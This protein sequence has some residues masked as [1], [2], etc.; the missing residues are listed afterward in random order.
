MKQ[1]HQIRSQ[2]SMHNGS[3]NSC[4]NKASR[5]TP[6]ISEGNSDVEEALVFKNDRL[7]VRKTLIES[8]QVGGEIT[9][10]ITRC[11]EGHWKFM[12]WRAYPWTF[13]WTKNPYW[14]HVWF[15][16]AF[17]R[18]EAGDTCHRFNL[19]PIDQGTHEVQTPFIWTITNLA[20]FSG[21]PNLELDLIA[22]TQLN[23]THRELGKSH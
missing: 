2:L 20:V 8:D 15:N 1:P 7:L 16:L 6:E 12:D 4:R 17:Q 11:T 5:I 14:W 18:S 21:Q 23:A 22:P 10:D 9:Y 3:G 13:K 19:S